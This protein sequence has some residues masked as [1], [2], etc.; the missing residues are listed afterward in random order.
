MN[1]WA[2]KERFHWSYFCSLQLGDDRG[3]R[4]DKKVLKQFLA[5]RSSSWMKDLE[6]Y[7]NITKSMGKQRNLELWLRV[8]E[9]NWKRKDENEGNK[10]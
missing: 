2:R 4:R 7:F 3:W 6:T 10:E 5:N 1:E 9:G 8:M